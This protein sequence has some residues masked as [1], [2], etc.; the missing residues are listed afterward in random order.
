MGLTILDAGVVIGFLERGDIHH[1]AAREAM[2]QAR[3]AG[4]RTVIAASAY[5]EVLVGAVRGGEDAVATVER[6][7]AA[8]PIEVVDIDSIIA[9]DAARLRAEH[10]PRLR[11]PGALVVAT[12]RVHKAQLL[13][14]TDHRWP[15]ASALGLADVRCLR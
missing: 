11:L 7:V 4:D 5:S 15:S 12:A 3:A 13:V 10:G 6:F 9:L 8:F 1:A 2:E 14:T